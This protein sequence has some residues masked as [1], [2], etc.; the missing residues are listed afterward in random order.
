M[1][2]F[3]QGVAPVYTKAGAGHTSLRDMS[4]PGLELEENGAISCAPRA[5]VD[6]PRATTQK[7]I[8]PP[9]SD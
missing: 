1:P 3:L 8:F 5:N 9:L 4:A 7:N 2:V 6:R